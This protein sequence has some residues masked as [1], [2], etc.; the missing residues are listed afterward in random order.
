VKETPGEEL[1]DP[2]TD[3]GDLTGH[4]VQI[5]GE[6]EES[7]ENDKDGTKTPTLSRKPS[8]NGNSTHGGN[9]TAGGTRTP[10]RSGQDTRTPSRSGQDSV[11]ASRQ[12]TAV[13]GNS[14]GRLSAGWH[15]SSRRSSR[16]TSS[17]AG[18]ET[19]TSVIKQ[20]VG[21]FL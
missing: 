12:G 19:A 9:G 20:C 3:F 10:S 4:D 15:R 6:E 2:V 16:P 13:R 18:S 5:G 14:A 21:S 17:I 7:K 1:P 11:A 8:F